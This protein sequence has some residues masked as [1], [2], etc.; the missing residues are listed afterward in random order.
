[1]RC[2]EPGQANRLAFAAD[3]YSLLPPNGGL[4]VCLNKGSDALSKVHLLIS[5]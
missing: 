3:A 4:L 1:M 5:L 2:S